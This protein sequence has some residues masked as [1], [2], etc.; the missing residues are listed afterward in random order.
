MLTMH[1]SV[2]S[3]TAL[4]DAVLLNLHFQKNKTNT[5]FLAWTHS[6]WDLSSLTRD[7]THPPCSES[8]ESFGL[9]GKDQK[10]YFLSEGK[11][12]HFAF[13]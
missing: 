1:R 11:P 10:E 2:P 3:E 13:L 5:I 7:L 8:T 9:P 4:S 6:F 12:F